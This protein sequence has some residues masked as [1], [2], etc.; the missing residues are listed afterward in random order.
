RSATGTTR[1][2]PGCSR[3]S[4]TY[5]SST[6]QWSTACGRSRRRSVTAGNVCRTS[7]SED[8]RTSRTCVI[9]VARSAFLLSA[10]ESPPGPSTARA[11]GEPRSS[12]K[13]LH[14]KRYPLAHRRAALR[15][16]H[17]P[18]RSASPPRVP[19]EPR[20][21]RRDRGRRLGQRRRDA[22]DRRRP[23]RARHPV[24]LAW[25][26]PAEAVRRR[27]GD[28]RLGAVHRRRRARVARAGGGHPQGAPQAGLARLPHAPA[29][30]LPRPLALARRGLPR[31]EPAALQPFERALERR[32][33]PREGALRGHARLARRRPAARLLRRPRHV[34]RAPEQVHDARGAPG[35][36]AGPPGELVSSRPL[37]ARA[38]FQVLRAA[39][40]VPRRRAGPAPHLHRLHEQLREVREA[41]RAAARGKAGGMK[42]L[43]TGVAGFIGMHCA[44]RLLERGDEV[45]GIDN[46]SPYYS[47]ELKQAR[48]A[49]IPRQGRFL[50]HEIDLAD[51]AA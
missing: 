26:R 36:R 24:R 12:S 39:P 16:H 47:V 37:A 14:Y 35:L 1:A 51:G 31:L 41:D 33:R 34:S 40:G 42:V 29:Q 21:R 48:L 27:P 43:V 8:M 2:T 23:R 32:P 17:H 20:L 46:L 38:L 50:W 45:V 9:F 13:P 6:A 25:P 10:V 30:P 22:G 4:G 7:P 18:Q 3:T 15:G 28:E 5:A 44:L 49:R 19:G 11:A